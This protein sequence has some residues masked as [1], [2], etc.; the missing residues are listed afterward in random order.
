MIPGGS[1]IASE[2]EK[3][4]VLCGGCVVTMLDNP[5]LEDWTSDVGK[6]GGLEMPIDREEAVGALE[7]A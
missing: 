6:F 7:V 2:A 5:S 4:L 1:T 3:V